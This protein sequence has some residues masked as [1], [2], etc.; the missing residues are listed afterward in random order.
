MATVPQQ[1]VQGENIVHYGGVRLRVN[2]SGNLRLTFYSL[3]DESSSAL[4]PIA[5]Q[6]TTGREPLRLANF[7]SQRGML[8]FQTTAINETFRVN[9][10]VVFQKE[11]WTSY[12]G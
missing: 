10:V 12:P 6:A 7:I 4:V 8:E 5:M 11:I 9:R 1:A 3:D 2:G